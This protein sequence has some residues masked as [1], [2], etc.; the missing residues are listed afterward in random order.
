MV[1]VHEARQLVLANAGETIMS[2]TRMTGRCR[3]RLNELLR[4]SCL[5]PDIVCAILEGRQPIGL[6]NSTL[7]DTLLPLDWQEQK[8]LLGFS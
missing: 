6:S 4:L 5:S 3:A 8:A 1:E 2:I 7:L